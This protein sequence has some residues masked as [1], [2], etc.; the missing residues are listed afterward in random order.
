MDRELENGMDP[1]IGSGKHINIYTKQAFCTQKG[2][3]ALPLQR[4]QTYN[5]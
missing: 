3:W 5:A 1:V 4:E 2:K